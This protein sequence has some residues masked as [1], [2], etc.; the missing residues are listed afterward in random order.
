MRCRGQLT[1]IIN[2]FIGSVLFLSEVK[3]KRRMLGLDLGPGDF[4]HGNQQIA[5]K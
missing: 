4:H 1:G 2:D 5:D 3:D